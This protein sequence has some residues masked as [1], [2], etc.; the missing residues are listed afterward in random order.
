MKPDTESSA[1]HP[2]EA[3]QDRAPEPTSWGKALGIAIGLAVLVGALVT[4]F[5]W[6]ASETRPR[7]VPVAVVGPPEAVALVDQQLSSVMS[8]AFDVEAAPDADTA[9]E[10]ILD[11]EVYGAIVLDPA[12]PPQLLT[13]SAASPAVAQVLQGVA[14]QMAQQGTGA[15]GPQVEDVVP[16]PDDDPRG[17]GFAAAALPMTLGGLL[18]GVALSFGVAG[19]ARVVTG[20]LVASAATGLVTALVVQVWLGSLEGNY[21]VNA[22]VIAFTVAAIASTLIGLNAVLGRPGIGL[23]ALVVLLLGNPLSG[24]PSAPE[25]LPSGWGAFGQFLPPGAGGTLLRSTA[26]FDG[27]AAGVP[28]LVLAAWMAGGLLLAALGRRRLRMGPPALAHA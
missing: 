20:A 21:W 14:T 7:D 9:R 12:G 26:F 6:P 8:G 15:S 5:A 28:L 3:T 19:A 23:G 27:A 22:G 13:A 16:L 24:V 2:A 17:T 18:V 4:A 11:R 25:M 10:L 1:G